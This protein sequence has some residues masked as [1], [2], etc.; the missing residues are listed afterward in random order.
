[1]LLLGCKFSIWGS[2]G[3][4]LIHLL[5][6]NTKFLTF[7]YIGKL[8]ALSKDIKPNEYI[9][10]GEQSYINGKTITWNNFFKK[11]NDKKVIAGKHVTCPYV[12]NETINQ[13]NIYKS[14]GDFI[15]PEIGNRALAC[16]EFGKNFSYLHIISDNV[17]NHD[18]LENL[19]N[20]RK[21]TILKKKKTIIQEN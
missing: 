10:T 20:K 18:I 9:A 2:T 1:M 13:I 3:Y 19:S 21:I 15:D 17:V 12:L 11:L 7:I 8:G 6:K 4:D 14:K 16:K 5:S